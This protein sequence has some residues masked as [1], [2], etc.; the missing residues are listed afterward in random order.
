[1]ARI[2]TFRFPPVVSGGAGPTTGFYQK[3]TD[4]FYILKGNG[5]SGLDFRCLNACFQCPSYAD[6]LLREIYEQYLFHFQQRR[7]SMHF[8]KNVSPT[9]FISSILKSQVL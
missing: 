3:R 1:M 8:Q 7:S 9:L 2:Q 6:L 4:N 5:L